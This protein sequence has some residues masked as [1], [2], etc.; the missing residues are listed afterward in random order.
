LI[1]IGAIIIGLGILKIKKSQV[2]VTW[3]TNCKK[4]DNDVSKVYDCE[5]TKFEEYCK[6]CYTELHY[7]LTEKN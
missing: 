2:K 6:E 3:M 1:A 7:Y 4:C 5:H